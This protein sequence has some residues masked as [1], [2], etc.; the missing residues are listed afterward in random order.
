MPYG[1]FWADMI[2]QTSR[3]TPGSYT[4]YV[5]AKS[6]E[7]EPAFIIDARR[8]RFGLN[9]EGPRI[10]CFC[11]AKGGAKLEFDFQSAL[12]NASF[13]VEDDPLGMR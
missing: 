7:G 2:Y 4:V 3:T 8:S 9:I 12:T 13:E 10:P 5:P 6:V 1:A 11:N